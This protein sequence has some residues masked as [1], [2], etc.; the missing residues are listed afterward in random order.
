MA[1]RGRSELLRALHEMLRKVS[2]QSVLISDTV[3]ARV[4]LNS[5]DLECLD[6]LYLAGPTTAGK[7]AAHSGLTTGAMTAVLDRLERR[8]FARRRRDPHDRRRVVVEALPRS[9]A[10]IEPFYAPLAARSEQLNARYT[11]EQ[12]ATIVDYMT[13]SLAIG[14][15]HVAWLQTQRPVRRRG[16]RPERAR[17]NNSREHEASADSVEGNRRI[18]P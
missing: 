11:D 12:L 14:A 18:V 16:G 4:G 13:Q 8:G 17:R 15:E 7:L 3:A 9:V 10:L 2:A 1:R 5:T 6:L